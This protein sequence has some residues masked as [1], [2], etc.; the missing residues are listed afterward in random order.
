MRGPVLVTGGAKRLG[1]YF[2]RALAEGGWR[3]VL[4]YG[5]SRDEAEALAEELGGAT[6]QAD[7]SQAEACESLVTRAAAAAGAPLT[8][9][10]NSASIFEHDTGE[11]VTSQGL[12]RHHAVN[13]S[14]PVVLASRFAAQAPA[15]D[16]VV[17]NILDQKLWNPNPDHLS[18]TLSKAALRE[19][20][21]RLAQSLA[22]VRVVGVAPGYCLPGPGEAQPE[23]EAKAAG[24]NILRR[25]L[26]PAHVAQAVR[27]AA[28]C[29]AVT[30][31]VILA[32]NGEHLVAAARDVS[33]G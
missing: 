13:L 21:G 2:A 22:P 27:F 18:Y 24:V 23:F 30:G 26:D 3:P 16:A 5:T 25:R 20:T 31:S 28:E 10:V 9:L 12:A 11:T 6:V 17:I 29:P 15:G 1:A 14:A 19:A 33:F 8:A 32:D 7:L 4:H